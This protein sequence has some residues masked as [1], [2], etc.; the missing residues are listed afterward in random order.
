MDTVHVK[1]KDSSPESGGHL[2]RGQLRMG[3]AVLFSYSVSRSA[4][5]QVGLARR[6]LYGLDFRIALGW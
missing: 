2:F 1:M 3:S 4:H 6:S 5:G